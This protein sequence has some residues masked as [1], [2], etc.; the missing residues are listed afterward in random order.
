MYLF[1]VVYVKGTIWKWIKITLGYILAFRLFPE[2]YWKCGNFDLAKNR[3]FSSTVLIG[4]PILEKLNHFLWTFY[5]VMRILWGVQW[6]MSG[7]HF[8]KIPLT[9]KRYFS[10]ITLRIDKNLHDFR[11]QILYVD[12]VIILHASGKKLPAYCT[13]RSFKKLSHPSACL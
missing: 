13:H 7:L 4:G 8:F 3:R 1:L 5:G 9:W 6:A 2:N 11:S 10:L 12:L